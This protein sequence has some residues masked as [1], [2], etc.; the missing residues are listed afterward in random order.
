MQDVTPSSVDFS[1]KHATTYHFTDVA[2]GT[3]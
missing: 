3:Y 1:R 2:P